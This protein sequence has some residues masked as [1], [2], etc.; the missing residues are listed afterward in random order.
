MKI[1]TSKQASVSLGSP[2]HIDSPRVALPRS[3]RAWVG[4]MVGCRSDDGS[5]F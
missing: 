3:A 5:T 4:V 2:T 1:R